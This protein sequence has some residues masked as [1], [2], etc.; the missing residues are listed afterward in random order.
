MLSFK[1][2][3]SFNNVSWSL[4]T[5]SSSTTLYPLKNYSYFIYLIIY[6]YKFTGLNHS[7]NVFVSL[8]A[9]NVVG[10]SPSSHVTAFMTAARMLIQNNFFFYS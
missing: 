8:Q 2:S 1:L 6:C 4:F 10:S 9:S 7:S 5:L 3:Y